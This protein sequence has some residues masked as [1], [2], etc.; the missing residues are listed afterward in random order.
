MGPQDSLSV[1]RQN[2][3]EQTPK[4]ELS[5]YQ[6]RIPPSNLWFSSSSA[7]ACL[8]LEPILY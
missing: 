4:P 3:D 5:I 8:R 6:V 7:L 1:E 2:R